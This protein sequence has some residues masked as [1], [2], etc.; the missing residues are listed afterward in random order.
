[1][2]QRSDSPH[3]TIAVIPE[4]ALDDTF[5]KNE[6]HQLDEASMPKPDLEY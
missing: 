5:D 4:E 2:S 1:V 6:Q 3:Q